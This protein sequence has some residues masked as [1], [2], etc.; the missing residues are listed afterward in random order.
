MGSLRV[1]DDVP[2]PTQDCETLKK[3]FQGWGTDEKAVIKVLG[4]RNESQ[5]KEIRE[6][7]Q[8]LYNESLIDD[9][10]S[11]LSGDF[12]NA[13]ALWTYDPAERDARLIN[14]ALHKKTSIFK[15]KK[16]VRDW[17]VIVEIACAFPPRHLMAVRRAYTSLFGCSIEEDVYSHVPLSPLRKVLVS[18]V[19]SNRHDKEVVDMNVATMEAAQL[20]ETIQKKQL[21]HDYVIS[22]LGTRSFYQLRATFASYK[23]QF[24]TS[25]DQDILKCG[26]GDLHTLLNVAVLCMNNPEKHFAEVIRT[27]VVGSGTDEDSLSR[28]IVTRAEID[29][30]KVK[31]EYERMYKTSVEED[32][33]GD[34]SGYYMDFLLTLLRTR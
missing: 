33:K 12:L 6:T 5:R 16:G 30:K 21:D 34:T 20:H 24:S 23:Q 25:L 19:S 32:V 22:I 2:S 29:M 7:Y 13:I 4:Y 31:F 14:D 26:S 1:P 28:A 11:E 3:A 18:L 9:L 10:R 17:Q 8:Q 27:S 15:T